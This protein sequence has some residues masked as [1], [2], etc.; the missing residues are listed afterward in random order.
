M[1]RDNQASSPTNRVATTVTAA[2]I[3]LAAWAVLHFWGLG[4]APFH[5]K[6]EAREAV[7]V[8]EI[9]HGGTWILPRRGGVE[10][11]RK[12]PL[13]YWLAALVSWGH[14][15]V[16]EWSVRAPSA[17]ASGAATLLVFGAATSLYGPLA[18][19]IAALTLLTSF[20]WLRAATS[21]RVDMTLT[22]GLTLA[23]TGLLL[24]RLRERPLYVFMLYIG[25]V[26]ATLSKGPV[27]IALPALQVLFLCA[28]DRSF[29]FMRRL[30]LAWGFSAVL[31]VTGTWYVL[32]AASGGHEFLTT[33]ILDENIY[34]FLGHAS[35]TGGHRHSVA[36]LALMLLAG[37]LP[38]TL[39]LPGL[40]ASLWQ[41][42]GT[43]SR[44]DP[45]LFAVVWCVTVFAF[46]AFATSKRA[47]YLLPLYPAMSLL[48]GW[49]VT[50][51]IRQRASAPRLTA[52]LAPVA[53]SSAIVF[54]VLALASAAQ[55]LGLPVFAAAAT[56]IIPAAAGEVPGIAG[57]AR[58][59]SIALSVLFSIATLGAAAAALACHARRWGWLFLGALVSVSSV[60]VATRQIILP[61]V[62]A[63]QTRRSFANTLRRIVQEPA[64]LASFRH[65]DYGTTFYWG[66]QIPIYDKA[67]LAGGP[68]YLIMSEKD[69]TRTADLER[70][71][72]EPV[73]GLRSPRTSNQGS[74]LLLRRVP[75][76]AWGRQ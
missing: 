58:S 56:L 33:Q 72:Y 73:I 46:Y 60:I 2:L 15:Q 1:E 53:W 30:H 11:P 61:I 12:P 24:L 50:A 74:L 29:A 8:P 55:A 54:I 75:Q 49:W 52:T 76:A 44:R 51:L 42:R 45:R 13:F 14:G 63:E 47:V 28:I 7:V 64:E 35:L 71:Y 59:H 26:W 20:E 69:W 67:E 5:T 18:G 36:Y 27:G 3:V 25:S 37:L 70:R 65:P 68:P 48:F 57:M 31:L 17:L 10:L 16:D 22:L 38:W 9:V 41:Q 23:F 4:K 32:A 19:S 66:R 62:A 6:G 21:A 34:R 43:L 39:F 40:G